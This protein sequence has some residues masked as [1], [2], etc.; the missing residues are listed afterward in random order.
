MRKTMDLNN[1][2]S[3]Q[4]S[5]FFLS[6]SRAERRE[7]GTTVTIGPSVPIIL[8]IQQVLDLTCGTLFADDIHCL[9]V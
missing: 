5:C 6:F 9:T 3:W 8:I 7:A 1:R 2:S 4:I